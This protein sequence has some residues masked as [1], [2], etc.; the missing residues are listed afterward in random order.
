MNKKIILFCLQ[1][2]LFCF[3]QLSNPTTTVYY[4]QIES[5]NRGSKNGPERLATLIFDKEKSIYTTQKDSLDNIAETKLRE[6]YPNEKGGGSV[7]TGLP[8]TKNG[9]QV[10][11]N[12]KRDTVW[13]SFLRGG[14]QHMKE[15]K[16]KISWKFDNETKK[17]GSYICNKAIT[18]FRGR[19]YTAW[20]AKQIPVPYGPWKLQGLPGLILEAYNTNQEIFYTYKSIEYPSKID[21]YEIK[22]IYNEK[23]KWLDFKGYI[24]FCDKNAQSTYERMIMLAKEFPGETPVKA[25]IEEN[26]KEISE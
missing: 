2:N 9:S 13:S 3:A 24:D 4:T 7:Y 18:K 6:F 25:K 14:L 21:N 19:D 22:P 1:I 11:T 10:Y 16:V 12:N 8:A 5:I 20:Y 23:D 26:F 17:I 15:P